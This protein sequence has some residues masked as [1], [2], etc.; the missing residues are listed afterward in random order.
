MVRYTALVPWGWAFVVL[1]GCV[2]LGWVVRYG[3][4]LGLARWFGK[5]KTQLDD[6]LVGRLRR[7]VLWWVALVGLAIAA[8]IAPITPRWLTVLDRSVLAL[9]VISA[10]VAA[11]NIVA[12]LLR[13]YAAKVSLALPATTLT[14]NIIRLVVLGLGVLLLLSNLGV[15]IA[16]LLTALGV[17][18]LAVALAL[19][20][21]LSNLFSDS[22]Y[23]SLGT[24]VWETTSSWTAALKDT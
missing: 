23:C 8:R 13:V 6:I 5:T 17:G 2:G 18:S 3:L 12:R 10:S 24:S 7:H 4:T 19:Q 22:T 15:S 14:E 1:V 9:F 20:E 21:T 11:A 16:P